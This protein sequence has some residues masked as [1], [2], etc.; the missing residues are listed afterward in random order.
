VICSNESLWRKYF[1]I[2]I[3]FF[4]LERLKEATVREQKLVKE[5]EAAQLEFDN[6]KQRETSKTQEVVGQRLAAEKKEANYRSLVQSHT[7]K[8]GK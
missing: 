8:R 3:L 5:L 1:N 7:Q 4:S 6:V 2:N